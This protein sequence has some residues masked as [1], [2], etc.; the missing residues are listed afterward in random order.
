M[1]FGSFY[2]F[3]SQPNEAQRRCGTLFS[4]FHRKSHYARPVQ[5]TRLGELASIGAKSCRVSISAFWDAS[6]VF[7]SARS[8]CGVGILQAGSRHHKQ[9]SRCLVQL[10]GWEY[11]GTN[12]SRA[13]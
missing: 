11:K 10:A 1:V 9:P 12:H 4:V 5:R 13:R 3:K 8:R 6:E 2:N 7:G